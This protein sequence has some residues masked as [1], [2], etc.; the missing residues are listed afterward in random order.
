MPGLNSCAAAKELVRLVQLCLRS[1]PLYTASSTCAVSIAIGGCFNASFEVVWD[2][3]KQLANI[4][5]MSA[6]SN[7]M[8][9]HPASKQGMRKL[10]V[11]ENLVGL[12]GETLNLHVRTVSTAVLSRSSSR[13]F[14]IWTSETLPFGFTTMDR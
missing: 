10:N 8:S 12:P 14:V 1:P 13:G 5:R 11:T 2:S 6:A 9:Y 3:R 7:F 4:K